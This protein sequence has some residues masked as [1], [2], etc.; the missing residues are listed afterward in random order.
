MIRI[1]HNLTVDY[2]KWS[3]LFVSGILGMYQRQRSFDFNV[4]FKDWILFALSIILASLANTLFFSRDNGVSFKIIFRHLVI[5]FFVGWVAY[6]IGRNFDLSFELRLIIV[7]L[8]AFS[9]EFFLRWLSEKYPKIFDR[10]LDRIL[11]PKDK[12]N[13]M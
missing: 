12:E 9:S 6:L 10:G 13:D 2:L 3:T 11:P 8:M 5:S 4:F 7:S 1:L